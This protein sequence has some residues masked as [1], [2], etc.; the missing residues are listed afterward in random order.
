MEVLVDGRELKKIVRC[1]HL[2]NQ[3]GRPRQILIGDGINIAPDKDR[4]KK[5]PHRIDLFGLLNVEFRDGSSPVG[6]RFD[7]AFFLE[8]TKRLADGG[9]RNIELL[10]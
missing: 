3:A 7:K 9:N 4:L 10:C 1:L 2:V 6:N 5:L 8:A